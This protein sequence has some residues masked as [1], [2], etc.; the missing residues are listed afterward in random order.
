[1]F[2]QILPA[3]PKIIFFVGPKEEYVDEACACATS[4]SYQVQ[5]RH[6]HRKREKRMLIGIILLLR[7]LRFR[8]KQVIKVMRAKDKGDKKTDSNKYK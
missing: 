6:R 4:N 5:T 7:S 3:R 1:M 2:L 8:T